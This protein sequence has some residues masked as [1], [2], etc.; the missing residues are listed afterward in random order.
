MMEF[1][2]QKLYVKYVNSEQ[3]RKVSIEA[4]TGSVL[5]KNMFLKISQKLQKNA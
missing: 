4:A 1:V 3:C 5:Y 2:M